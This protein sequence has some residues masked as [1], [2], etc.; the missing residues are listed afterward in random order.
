MTTRRQILAL[1]G[2]AGLA[3]GA[4]LIPS[5]RAQ[6]APSTKPDI[7]A[8][9]DE[10]EDYIVGKQTASG[11]LRGPT[12][13]LLQPYF[14]NWAAMGLA[15]ANT[16]RSREALGNFISWFLAH[17]NTAETDPYGI[18]GTVNIWNY[19]AATDTETDTGTTSATDAQS[20]V[21]LITAYQA[22]KT[23]D[24]D[25]QHLV[26]EN[27][28]KYDLM[29]QVTTKPDH[30]VREPDGLCWARPVLKMK[31][32]QDNAVVQLGLA[33]LAWLMRRGGRGQR[34]AFYAA[35]AEETRQAILKVLWDEEYA[36][37]AWGHGA[38][39]L[40]RSDPHKIF[41]P[42]AWC[43]YWQVQMEVTKPQDRRSKLAWAA[44]VDAHPRWMEHDIDNNFA[45]TE[46]AVSAVRMGE[47]ENAIA[48]LQ[49]SREKY[50]GD[51]WSTPQWYHGEAGHFLRAARLLVDAGYSR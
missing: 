49:T 44:F 22:F 1:S 17:Q 13:D 33:N 12:D 10:Q 36:N 51:N 26:M 24:R 21:P 19:D 9:M 11:S 40:K 6:A 8:W 43:Q 15:A 27:L 28:D 20:T 41:M 30:G 23:G 37:W 46:M 3:A 42:D 48:H 34:G 35:K 50:A 7:R 14:S 39:L 2:A 47:P 25:L 45:H 4:T 16:A 31:Y 5:T 32:V 38:T 29:G 18:P